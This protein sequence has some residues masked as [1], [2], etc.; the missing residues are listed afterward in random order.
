[1]V[2]PCIILRNLH[3]LQLFQ[4]GFLGNLVLSLIGIVLQMAYVCDITYI[5]HL[6]S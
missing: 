3:R 1:M 5:T 2:A 6:I 4:T